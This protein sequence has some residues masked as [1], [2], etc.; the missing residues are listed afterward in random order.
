MF[1][2]QNFLKQKKFLTD[3]FDI[4][5]LDQ[6]MYERTVFIRKNSCLKLPDAMIYANSPK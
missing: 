6:D 4:I 5:E 2:R 3:I 1:R